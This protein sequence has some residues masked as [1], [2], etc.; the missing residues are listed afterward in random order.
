MHLSYQEASFPRVAVTKEADLQGHQV[1]IPLIV[2]AQRRTPHGGGRLPVLLRHE[3]RWRDARLEPAVPAAAAERGAVQKVVPDGAE[4]AAEEG[5]PEEASPAE[6]GHGSA[7]T[8]GWR[9]RSAIN[10][11]EEPKTRGVVLF[12]AMLISFIIYPCND[13]ISLFVARASN[14]AVASQ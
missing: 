5:D 12:L 4:E 6:A 3:M 7:A 9:P 14:S 10:R 2:R 11:G 8:D 1:R 13:N